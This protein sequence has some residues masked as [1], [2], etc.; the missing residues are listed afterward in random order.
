MHNAGSHK[1]T[2]TVGEEKVSSA[3]LPNNDTCHSAV[4]EVNELCVEFA[5][6]EGQYRAVDGV[7]FELRRG[8]TVGLVGESGS[9]KTVTALSIMQLLPK[10][11]GRVLSGSIH[12]L[13]QELVGRPEHELRALRGNRISMIFQEP[14]T[15]LNP[16][17]TVGDQ[18]AEV[19][20]V[21]KGLSRREALEETLKLFELVKIAAPRERLHAY[22]H[23]LSGGMRQRVMIAMAIACNPDLLIADE[24]TTALDVT[25]QA[26]ILALLEELRVQ[27]SAAILLITHDLGIVAEMCDEV[28][29]MYAGQIVEQAD[30]YTLFSRP[31]HPYTLGLLRSLPK[32]EHGRSR[33]TLY[34]IPGTVPDPRHFPSGCRF[35]PRCEFAETRCKSE[36]PAFAH[37]DKNHLVRC[38]LWDKIESREL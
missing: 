34:S 12:F 8:A 26:Q 23:Q 6:A 25:V 2:E 32:M 17:M 20:R 36:I 33:Q 7:T 4:L 27:S 37:A 11:T 21:H 3:A 38:H 1:G 16:L 28:L 14:T 30:V 15:C 18:V 10:P 5:T 31:L 24:P 13:G 19:L 35:H 9:G 29:V 22:P